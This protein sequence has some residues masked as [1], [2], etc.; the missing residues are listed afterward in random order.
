MQG[1]YNNFIPLPLVH[2]MD[3]HGSQ[4]VHIAPE[5]FKVARAEFPDQI[6]IWQKALPRTLEGGLESV[7]KRGP[8]LVS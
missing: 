3:E 5:A 1:L 4:H 7:R 8:I 6:D 2:L